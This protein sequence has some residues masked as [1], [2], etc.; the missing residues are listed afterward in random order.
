MW[1]VHLFKF[2]S[3]LNPLLSPERRLRRR[4]CR[5]SRTVNAREPRVAYDTSLAT[6]TKLAGVDESS[7][8]LASVTYRTDRGRVHR[9]RC[10]S[11]WATGNPQARVADPTRDSARQFKQAAHCARSLCLVSWLSNVSWKG[12]VSS[13]GSIAADSSVASGR[14]PG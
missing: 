6:L 8:F 12:E 3:K 14:Q 5:T 10:A 4:I 9:C 13:P 11:H 2:C 7:R 1:H